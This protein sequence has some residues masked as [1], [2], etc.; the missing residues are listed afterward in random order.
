MQIAT[1]HAERQ[2]V[3]TGQ[4]VEER[5]FL[6]WIASEGG[7]VVCRHAKMAAFVESDFADAAFALLDQAAMTTGITLQC[8]AVEVLSQLRRTFGGHRVEDGGEWR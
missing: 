2:S 4:D 8:A 3:G 6:S 5:F 1:Q 7:D